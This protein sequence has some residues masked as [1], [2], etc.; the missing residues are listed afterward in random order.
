[1]IRKPRVLRRALFG[2]FKQRINEA[3]RTVVASKSPATLGA[4]APVAEWPPHRALTVTL[5]TQPADQNART[6]APT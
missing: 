3:A 1:M 6:Y 4:D 5:A 2:V